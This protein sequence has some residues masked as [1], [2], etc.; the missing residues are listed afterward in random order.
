MNLSGAKPRAHGSIASGVNVTAT[1]AG[2]VLPFSSLFGG[3]DADGDALTYYLY[4]SNTAAN[5]GHFV[6]NGK[7]V[8]AQTIYQVTAAQLA[9]TTFVAGAN[10]VSDDIY[11]QTYDGKVYSGWNTHLNLSVPGLAQNHA[12]TVSTPSGVNVTATSTGQVFQFSSL[13]TGNDADGD[14]LTY[15]LYDSNTAANSGHFVVNGAIVPAQTIYQVTAAQLAQTTFVAGANGVIDDIYVQT[16]D[17]KAYSGWNTHVNLS[18]PAAAAAQNMAPTMPDVTDGS[19]VFPAQVTD[20]AGSVS[21]RSAASDDVTLYSFSSV[22]GGAEPSSS[23]TNVNPGGQ[24]LG[25]RA[26]SRPARSV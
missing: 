16:Y 4:D 12:P 2:Q 24:C 13:F 22:N 7:E 17:G 21:A 8:P 9:Q 11:V 26:A 3:N 6:V 1:S 14:A 10:G 20:I 18:A 19:L 23:P 5:S 15:Y 25:L